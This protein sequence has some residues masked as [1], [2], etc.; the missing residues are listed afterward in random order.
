MPIVEL[1]Q[2]IIL[3]DVTKSQTHLLKAFIARYPTNRGKIYNKPREQACDLKQQTPPDEA[4]RML[5]RYMVYFHQKF[6]TNR[7]FR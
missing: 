4:A 1:Y 6:I 3:S 5:R 7:L 2:N